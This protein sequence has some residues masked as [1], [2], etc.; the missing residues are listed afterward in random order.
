MAEGAWDTSAII[1]VIGAR[2]YYGDKGSTVE[3]VA[4]AFLVHKNPVSLAFCIT[5]LISPR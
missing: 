2:A 1:A 3:G 5:R 4:G